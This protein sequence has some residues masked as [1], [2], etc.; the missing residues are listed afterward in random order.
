MALVSQAV[1]ARMCKVTPK[2][3]TKW[4]QEGR[5]VLQGNLVDVEATDVLMKRFRRKGSPIALTPEEAHA[6]KNKKGN[7]E[8]IKGNKPSVTLPKGNDG[9][10][11]LRCAE[12]LDRLKSMDWTQK[13]EWSDEEA[14]MQRA[15]F[16]AKCV[17]WEVVQSTMR[18]DGHWGGLQVRDVRN[19]K[20][21]ELS[22]DFVIG[23]FG[24]ELWPSEVLRLV[25]EELESDFDDS[26]TQDVRPDLLRLIAHPFHEQDRRAS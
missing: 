4:K 3:V 22:E 7:G 2:S 6:T 20:S 9:F 16:A 18:D 11:T 24:Y 12:I 13:F 26:D 1:F 10:V 23:G 19:N 15:E 25:R 14:L 21:G 5:I 17:G 8:R